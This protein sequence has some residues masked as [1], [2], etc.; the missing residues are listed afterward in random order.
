[1]TLI[2]IRNYYL[3]RVAV[4]L[5][6]RH[7]CYELVIACTSF[8]AV[9]TSCTRWME[10]IASQSCSTA[11]LIAVNKFLA[12]VRVSFEVYHRNS[13]TISHHIH[14]VWHNIWGF[15]VELLSVDLWLYQRR[16]WGVA[17]RISCSN[18]MS[19][20][21]SPLMLQLSNPKFKVEEYLLIAT[22]SFLTYSSVMQIEA[23][24]T[25]Q[26]SVE[27]LQTTRRYKPQ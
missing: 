21:I 8:V 19:F 16:H 12:N 22:V 5:A 2:Y 23:I 14:S 3:E 6:V 7:L 20:Y 15:F 10:W 11:L 27:L 4:W 9:Q 13:F 1:M 26:R 18:A 24:P 17:Y 25:S